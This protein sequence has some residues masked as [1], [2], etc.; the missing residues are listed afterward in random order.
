MKNE[1]ISVIVPV[2]NVE[3]YLNK[4]LSSVVCQT[5]KNLEII[6][7]DDGSTDSSGK[8]CDEWALKDSR[9]KVVHKQNGGLSSA[10]NEG[11]N[12]AT[13]NFIAF[14]DSDDHI[15]PDM[16]ETLLKNLRANDSDICI[17][18]FVMEDEQGEIVSDCKPLISQTSPGKEALKWLSEPRQDRYCVAWNKLYKKELFDEIRFPLGLIHEDQWIAHY[19]FF[20]AKKITCIPD[21]L[22]HYLIRS[23]SIMQASNPMKHFS[24][25]DAI[26]DRIS[27]YEQNSLTHLLL[28]V[29]KTMF[30]L[31]KFYLKKCFNFQNFSR[32]EFKQLK[33]YANTCFDFFKEC[34]EKNPEQYTAQDIT[35]RK[36]IYKFSFKDHINLRFGKKLRSTKAYNLFSKIKQRLKKQTKE[37]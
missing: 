21:V 20:N 29:E 28:G 7:I 24:D 37:N 27:F 32:K 26:L 15:E 30:D 13:G 16:I 3:K 2:F 19:V 18:S 34:L 1:L 4:C 11:L 8:L 23:N 35:E 25:I 12:I 14:V 33:L 17:C 36:Q 6:L 9:I 10:R 5:H 31:F 22:Y